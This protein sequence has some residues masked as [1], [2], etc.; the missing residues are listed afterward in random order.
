MAVAELFTVDSGPEGQF[1]ELPALQRLCGDGGAH[2]GVGWTYIHGPTLAPDAGSGE[3]T[4]WS[5]VVLLGHLRRGI[6]RINP[7]LPTEAVQRALELALTSTSPSVIEDHRR[8]HR[9][10]LSGVPVAYRDGDDIERHAHAKLVDFDDLSKNE[11]VAVN[12]LTIIVGG[13][14][15]RPD[16]VLYVNGLPLGEIEAKAPGLAKP[17]EEAVNQ[18]AHYKET[19]PPLYRFV[20][21]VGVTDLM[22]AVVGTIT[23]P[24]EHFAEWKTMSED[25]AEK[26]RPQLDLMI[27]GVFAPERFMELIR[28]FVLFETDGARTWKVMAKYHQVHA[29]TAAVESAARAM[30]SDRRGGLIWHTQGAGKSYTMVFFVNKLRHDERFANP[31]VVAVTDRTDLD[32][33]LADTFTATHLEPQ[34]QQAD[35]IRRTPSS[36]AESKSLYELLQVPAGGIVFTTIQKFAPP[37]GED[38][39]PVLSERANVIVM[40]DEAHRSQY[41]TFAEN[42]TL[43]LPN[44]TRIGFTGTPIEKG[45]RSTR[46]VFGDYVSIYRMRQA[47][48]DRAT[49]PIFYESRQIK[50]DVEDQ[51]E[52]ERVEEVLEDEEEEAARRLVTSWAKLEKVVGAPDRLAKLADDLA[53]HFNARCETLAGKAMVVAYSRRVAA[54]LADLLGQRLG[55]DAVDCVI[56]AQATDDP[57]I[58]RFRRSKPQLRELA[59]RF[60][61]PDDPLRIVVV[62]DM[63]LTGFDA[64]VLHTLYIDKPMRDHGLLQAIARVNRVFKDKPGGLVVDYIGI[65]EDLRSSLLAYDDEDIDDP[66]IPAAQAVARLWEKYEVICD[67]LHPVGYRQGELH[68][69]ADKAALFLDAYNHVLD[70]EELTQTFLDAQLAL[71]KWYALARTQPA[72]LELRDEIGFFNRLGAEV[73]KITTPD[74]QASKEAEQTVRQFMSEGLAAGDVLD[75][76]GLADKDRPEISVLSDDFLDLIAQRTDQ[77]NIQRRLLQKLLDDQ[78]K[79]RRRTNNLQ[80]K[81]FGDEIEAVLKRYELRQLSSAEVVERLIEIAKRLRDSAHRHEELG[82]TEEEAAFYDA[83]AGGV[84]HVKA[85]PDLAALAHQLAENIRKDL[86]VDWTD[87]EATEAK[88]RTKI[89]RLLRRNKDKLPKLQ[90]AGSNA[91]SG[92]DFADGDINYFTQLVLDQAKSLYRYWPEVG[93]RLFDDA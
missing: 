6:Q 49:V 48:E 66:V 70:T 61:D 92:G 1:V 84:E 38:D 17:S 78:L 83:L 87:R 39:M 67:L 76:F 10:L 21:I 25:P 28:D 68:L 80:A 69:V 24:A 59:K 44:A 73:R 19:I 42:I 8:F 81:R 47:Q 52:L 35:E 43:A 13:S 53:P 54:Q 33:Q 77:Q 5:D 9:L 2:P 23:T 22:K 93:D 32:N 62:K 31:T 18:V 3:R 82:L 85:D 12:Q 40:A 57:E 4:R 63:W 75:V 37:T 51:D 46:L 55:G 91:G 15:R 65:G 45:D 11:F 34:C 88:I 26:A 14:N 29:V 36:A 60:R 50:L 71:A 64:P 86:S 56:S 41:D 79:A 72:A 74:G 20:E 7:H 16:I 27:E 58:S 30:V 89:K 90:P